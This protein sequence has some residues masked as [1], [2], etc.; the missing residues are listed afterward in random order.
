MCAKCLGT[1]GGGTACNGGSGESLAC[2]FVGIVQ[3]P[4]KWVAV[5]SDCLGC[6]D[7]V[8]AWKGQFPDFL[9]GVL[10]YVSAEFE[11]LVV[12]LETPNSIDHQATSPAKRLA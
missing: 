6:L 1:G 12:A 5:C 10:K 2:S 9:R 8:D 7:C 3:S 11:R 4:C